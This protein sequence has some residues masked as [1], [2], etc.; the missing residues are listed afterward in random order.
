LVKSQQENN[1]NRLN[2]KFQE[3]SRRN[4]HALICYIVAG[5]PDIKTTEEIVSS[6]VAGGV[7]IIELGLPFSD[8]IADGPTI[9]EASYHALL[10]GV[11][12]EKCL[13]ISKKIRKKFP[14]LPVVAMTYSNIVLRSGFGKFMAKSKD[15]G[16]DGFILP[17]M[18]IEEADSYINDASQLGLA[19]I[20]LVSP[21]TTPVRLQSIMCKSSGFVYMVSVYGITGARK[22]FEDYTIHAIKNVK[23]VAGGKIPVAV[24]FGISSPSQA[25]FMINA[26]ADAII[27][28]SAI[29]NKI[30]AFTDKKKMLQE[31]QLFA[32]KMK[33]AC[34]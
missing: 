16:I 4:D 10:Q 12:P 13:K 21:N 32:M 20:F 26:G 3:L 25:K 8:P 2:R 9:Q 18:A 28:G 24:G 33:K 27:V 1:N 22:S 29:I 15:C 34:K 14:N 17:D 11:T 6:L 5:Y 30:K 7:D 23:D 31:L 19:T